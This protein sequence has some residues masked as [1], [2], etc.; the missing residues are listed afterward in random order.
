MLIFPILILTIYRRHFGEW[1]LTISKKM[2]LEFYQRRNSHLISCLAQQHALAWRHAPQ[3]VDQAWFLV[4]LA[5]PSCR[6]S[7]WQFSRWWRW[8]SRQFRL[9]KLASKLTLSFASSIVELERR[10]LA[11]LD[12]VGLEPS[13]R[14]AG[15]SWDTRVN[16]RKSEEWQLNQ[17]ILTLRSIDRAPPI[18][19]SPPGT[20]GR[21]KIGTECWIA[22]PRSCMPG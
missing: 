3:T 8:R 18:G 13:E 17:I 10:L 20:P 19:G 15:W 4:E 11:C 9:Y 12:Q 21:S 14:Q 2:H 1:H 6:I 16:Y 22:W 7:S 5:C